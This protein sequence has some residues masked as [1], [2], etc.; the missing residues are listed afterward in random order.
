M[1]HLFILLLCLATF[2]SCRH[3]P[4]AF[5]YRS[6][7]VDGWEPGDTL[8][9]HI[10]SIQES[11]N[12]MLTLGIRT[13]ASTPYPFQTLW[14]VVQQKWYNPATLRIDTVE[15]RLTDEKGDI[16]GHG[17][18]LYQFT[19]PFLTQHLQAGSSADFSIIHIMRREMLPGIS[20][21]GI[22]LQRQ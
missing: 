11:G 15:C 13:S 19:Q 3:Q 1:R 21:V 9:F 20:S 4:S 17:V 10:D 22:K 18:S 12:Y 16:A 7:S 5:A 2:A 6:T 14:L 8:H